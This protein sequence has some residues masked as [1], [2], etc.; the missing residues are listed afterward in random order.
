MLPIVKLALKV[1]LQLNIFKIKQDNFNNFF[2]I[3]ESAIYALH[4]T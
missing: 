3:L 4:E 1:I 2:Q